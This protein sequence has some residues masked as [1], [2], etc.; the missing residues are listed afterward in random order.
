MYVPHVR[1]RVR[2]AGR[3]GDFLVIQVDQERQEVDLVPFP[4]GVFVE[5]SFPF[6]KLE[7]YRESP[8]LESA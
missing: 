5:G 1:E 8:P 3:S 4:V 6:S 7:P 2:V